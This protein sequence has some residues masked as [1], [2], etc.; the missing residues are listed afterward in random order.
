MPCHYYPLREL[1]LDQNFSSPPRLHRNAAEPIMF[2]YL[3][4][5]AALQASFFYPWTDRGVAFT[6]VFRHAVVVLG[7][8]CSFAFVSLSICR[9][10]SVSCAYHS[11]Q[12]LPLSATCC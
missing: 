1:L 7:V 9:T 8:V 4:P 10:N 5:P 12:R 11:L 6:L 3:A 2:I